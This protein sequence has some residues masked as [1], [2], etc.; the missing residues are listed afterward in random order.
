MINLGSEPV[1]I[2]RGMRIAQ[3]LVVPLPRVEWEEVDV[4]P[5]SD[6]GSGGFGHTGN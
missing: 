5:D 1:T 2:E 4:L 6:R 3:F